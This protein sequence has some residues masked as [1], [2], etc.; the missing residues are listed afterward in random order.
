MEWRTADL[1][2]KGADEKVS[3]FLI[4]TRGSRLFRGHNAV[5]HGKVKCHGVNIDA[6]A[7]ATLPLPSLTRLSSGH[8]VAYVTLALH[9]GTHCTHC[10]RENLP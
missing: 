10:I 9:T 1:R 5:G 4:G 7:L 3:G 2:A 6:L 8:W